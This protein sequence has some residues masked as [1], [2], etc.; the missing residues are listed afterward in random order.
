MFVP[1]FSKA[2]NKP[3]GGGCN[4]ACGEPGSGKAEEERGDF[5]GS[6]LGSDLRK[7]G[8]REGCGGLLLG[9]LGRGREEDGRETERKRLS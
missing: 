3:P 5:D 8:G 4:D 2:K 1:C 6:W 9:E 7:R